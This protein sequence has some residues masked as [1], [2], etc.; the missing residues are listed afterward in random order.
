MEEQRVE[1]WKVGGRMGG[2]RRKMRRWM[3]EGRRVDG[4][5]EDGW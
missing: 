2:E 4:G 3:V 1:E 5:V